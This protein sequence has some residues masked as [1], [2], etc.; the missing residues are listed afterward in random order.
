MRLDTHGCRL[1]GLDDDAEG[2][3][4]C[5]LSILDES[6]LGERRDGLTAN[7]LVQQTDK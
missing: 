3:E 5:S 4:Q 6:A 1:I 2:G 7:R